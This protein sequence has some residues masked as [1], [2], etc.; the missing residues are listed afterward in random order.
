[1]EQ[2]VDMA[3]S[4]LGSSGSGGDRRCERALDWDR[5]RGGGAN[6]SSGSFGSNA[7]SAI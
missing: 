5:Y 2:L 6:H 1:M 3:V 4:A 7:A